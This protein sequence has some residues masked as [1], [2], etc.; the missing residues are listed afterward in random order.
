MANKVED[1]MDAFPNVHWT[2]GSEIHRS[3]AIES[4]V[5]FGTTDPKVI[6]HVLNETG[7]A[8]FMYKFYIKRFG[9]AELLL[10]EVEFKNLVLVDLV[11]HAKGL[12]D[13]SSDSKITNPK[14]GNQFHR[15]GLLG[16]LVIAIRVW[17][18]PNP[19]HAEP[20]YSVG[21]RIRVENHNEEEII[22][23]RMRETA[24]QVA[25][26]IEV[27]HEE[28]FEINEPDNMSSVKNAMVEKLKQTI[29]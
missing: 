23:V 19:G 9:D 4:K 11:R 27:L 25:Q 17:C 8:N 20:L 29:H 21:C 26:E 3:I 13:I 14:S 5:D 1:I 2:G 10:T 16:G 28:L 12:P 6:A 18:D 22:R 15:I 24:E 7:I